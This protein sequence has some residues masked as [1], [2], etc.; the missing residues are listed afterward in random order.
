M[1][2]PFQING[3][4]NSAGQTVDG[5]RSDLMIGSPKDDTELSSKAVG[6]I[7]LS[8]SLPTELP[9]HIHNFAAQIV[10]ID[11]EYK[12]LQEKAQ[13]SRELN[14]LRSRLLLGRKQIK[15]GNFTSNAAI[16]ALVVSKKISALDDLNI[17]KKSVDGSS[18]VDKSISKKAFSSQSNYDQL[19]KD[20]S[21]AGIEDQQ[22]VLLRID[23]ALTTLNNI[24]SKINDDHSSTSNRIMDLTGSISS[25]NVARSTVDK[26]KISINVA[27]NAVDMIVTNIK[28][29]VLSHGKVSSDMVRLV[30][31]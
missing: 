17:I 21:V 13:K 3:L 27:S 20:T 5:V 25:L 24:I 22:N 10:Q 11:N 18:V 12:L 4:P 9:P 14:E 31:V 16:D 15:L 1:I 23:D 26:T 28:T 2:G 19:N 29:A 8:Q 30:L 7:A 6:G